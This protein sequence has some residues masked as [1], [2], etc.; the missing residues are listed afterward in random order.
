MKK[1][2]QEELKEIL[3][4]DKTGAVDMDKILQ[5]QA[6]QQA[7]DLSAEEYAKIREQL[8]NQMGSLKVKKELRLELRQ[9]ELY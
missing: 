4:A 1:T 7:L 8:Q 2:F 3:D 6:K 9:P 5:D